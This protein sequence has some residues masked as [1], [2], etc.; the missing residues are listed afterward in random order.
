[1]KRACLILPLVFLNLSCQD[2]G[3]P[4]YPEPLAPEPP[5]RLAVSP[6]YCV[7]G[8]PIVLSHEGFHPEWYDAIRFTGNV[9]VHPD[10][11]DSTSWY[12]RV[13]FG[14]FSGYVSLK[15]E[16]N[17]DSVQ[18][19]VLEFYDP[20]TLEMLWYNLDIPLTSQ[21]AIIY[22]P[23]FRWPHSWTVTKR[24]DTV[25][26]Y[27]EMEYPNGWDRVTVLFRDN[28]SA[29]FENLFGY[30][31]VLGRINFVNPVA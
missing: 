22:N 17:H 21:D 11:T 1:M 16:G 15:S 2:Y 13:P 6:I 30:L 27:V 31:F 4:S 18:I 10:S 24:S 23:L 19:T 3:G 29:G 12:V 5:K 7:I 20:D 26:F 25:S 8:T 28:G 9:E 14:A